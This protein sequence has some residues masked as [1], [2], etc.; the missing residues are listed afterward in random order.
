MLDNSMLYQ[1]CDVDLSKHLEKMRSTERGILTHNL[2]VAT[3]ATAKRLKIHD[4]E[5]FWSREF[6]SVLSVTEQPR[7]LEIKN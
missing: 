6:L 4:E 3:E 2:I 5:K 7:Y 1:R